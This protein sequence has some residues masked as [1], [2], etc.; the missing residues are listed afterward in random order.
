MLKLLDIILPET[1]TKYIF[2]LGGKRKKR[3]ERSKFWTIW[4]LN[5][6]H[7]QVPTNIAQRSHPAYDMEV[8]QAIREIAIATDQ[9][10]PEVY[11][12]L[13]CNQVSPVLKAFKISPF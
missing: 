12:I 10:I 9:T 1:L 13:I 2:F 6:Y 4:K 8:A 7:I 5:G 11:E 3:L